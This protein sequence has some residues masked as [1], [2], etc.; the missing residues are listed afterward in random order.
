MQKSSHLEWCLGQTGSLVK[1]VLRFEIGSR[2]RIRSQA[3]SRRERLRQWQPSRMAERLHHRALMSLQKTV[4]QTSNS[5]VAQHGRFYT[6]LQP[7]TPSAPRT[8]NSPTCSHSYTRFAYS[9][10]VP[11]VRRTWENACAQIHLTFG[12]ESSLVGGFAS[13]TMR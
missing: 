12:I 11:T 5:S 2:Q 1:S 13:G 6:P 8:S 10:L 7:T 9:I 4:L 3:Q